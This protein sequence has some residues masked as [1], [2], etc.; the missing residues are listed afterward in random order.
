[1]DMQLESGL[2]PGDFVVW[3]C[4]TLSILLSLPS[5]RWSFNGDQYWGLVARI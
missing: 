1:V 3:K 5:I 2:V 4:G